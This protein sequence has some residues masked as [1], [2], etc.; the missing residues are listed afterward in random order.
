MILNTQLLGLSLFFIFSLFFRYSVYA[1]NAYKHSKIVEIPDLSFVGKVYSGLDILEQM[2][3]R[4]IRNKSIAILTNQSAVNRNNK[5]ILDILSNYPDIKV[6]FLLSMEY[7]IWSTND[8]RS[9]MVGR[10]GL[11]PIHKAQIIDLFKIY[12]YPPSWVMDNIDLIL[13]DYQDTGTRYSTFTATLSKVF[14]S[15]SNYEIPIFI[16]D[17]PNPIRGDLISG[18]IP[19]PEFQ[20]FESYHLFPIRHGLTIGEISLM[21]NE[22]GWIKDL[23]KVQLNI[24][25]MANWERSMWF[26]DTKL[27]NKN[28]TP[29][30]KKSS[31][32][33]A[34]V[35]M[36]LFRGTNL[37]IGFGTDIPYLLVGA[38]WLSTNYLLDKLKEQNLNGVEFKEIEYR[39]KGSTYYKRVPKYDNLKCSGI[40]LKIVN[41]NTFEPIKTATSLLILINQLFPRQFQWEENNY[42]DLLFG[43]NELRILAAQKKS[44]DHLPALWSKDIY[45]FNEFRQPFLIY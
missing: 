44:P 41:E 38:P 32:L 24:I 14:E 23:K 20:S 26:K 40:E 9:K 42:I 31:S 19:R 7:G 36:D 1:N 3:F 6:S 11:S 5:H 21:I 2:D 8:K 4:P 17:R 16:L 15:A 29:F 18:P 27:P 12:R 43:S 30:L 34:Y 39:P 28:L 33:L 25:P 13:V 35:G 37:N 45:K 10:D 22:M